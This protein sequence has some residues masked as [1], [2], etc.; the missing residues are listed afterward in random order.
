MQN[1]YIERFNRTS[2]EEV[3]NAYVFEALGEVRRVTLTGS[4]A[5]TN[6]GPMIPSAIHPHG[7]T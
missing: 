6:S 5:T 7:S 1:G 2:R 3:L 4:F